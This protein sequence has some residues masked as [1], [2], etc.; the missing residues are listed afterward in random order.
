MLRIPTPVPAG[1]PP[2][3]TTVAAGSAG[4]Y[5]ITQQPAAPFAVVPAARWRCRPRLPTATPVPIAAP[6]AAAPKAALRSTKLAVKSKKVGVSV[7]C[8]SA[9]EACAG[10][11]RLR[12]ASKVQGRQ[13]E[14]AR[15]PDQGGPVLR[16]GQRQ[17]A[18]SGSR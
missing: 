18:R 12:T 11:V 9:G 7:G 3:G 8:A 4:R 16:R 5:A 1:A 10:T 14:Q 17:R 2:T 15:L 13:V 6:K